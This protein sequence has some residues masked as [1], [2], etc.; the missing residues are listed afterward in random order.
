MT[1]TA[2]RLTLRGGPRADLRHPRCARR[3]P[4]DPQLDAVLDV[5]VRDGEIAE[6]GDALREPAGAEVVDADGLT[7]L[8]GLIDPH[9]HLRTPGQEHEET[10]ATGTLAAA[11]GGFTTILAMPNTDP[12]VD[13][14]GDPRR[15]ARPAPRARPPCALGFLAAI[16]VG[17]RGEQLAEL[18]SLADAGAVG[19]SDDGRPVASAGLLRRALQYASITGRVLSLH[20][21]ELSLSARRGDARGRRLGGARDARLPAVAESTMVGRDLR[22]ARY[23]GQPLHLCHLHVAESVE[24]VRWARAPAST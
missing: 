3:R 18:A 13:T 12:V 5:L 10:I 4:G 21:E 7:L 1:R 14:A 17:Q 16:S 6:L 22:L 24:E 23:E 19:F 11:A 9:V 20:C 8:P 15:A 2:G